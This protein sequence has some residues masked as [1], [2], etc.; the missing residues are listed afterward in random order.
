MILLVS[1]DDGKNAHLQKL[2]KASDNLKL[3]KVDMLNYDDVASAIAGCEG[4]FHV[5]SPVI[6][7]KVPDPEAGTLCSYI[8]YSNSPCS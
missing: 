4:V 2:E 1:D 6:S 3:F 5:A 7:T 8:L